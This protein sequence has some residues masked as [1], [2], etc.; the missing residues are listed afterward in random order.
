MIMQAQLETTMRQTGDAV[1]E[2]L[3]YWLGRS[4]VSIYAH[5]LLDLDVKWHAPLPGGAKILAANHPTTTDPFIILTL[6]PE[7]ISVLVTGGAFDVPL[8]GSYLRQAGHVP[9]L[10][11][12]GGRTVQQARELLEAG[13][14]VAIFPEGAL[15]PT[16]VG[17]GPTE[18]GQGP[19]EVGQGPTEV[20][21]GPT[22]VGQGP[23]GVRQGP[24]E[25]TM[26][27][28]QPHSGVARLA[29][30]TGAPVI[31]VGISLDQA[32]IRLVNVEM[33]GQAEEG[34]I[35]TGG[36]YA[37]TVGKPIWLKGNVA[38]W[39]FVHLVS[40]RIMD[41]IRRLSH[42]SSQRLSRE[43][44]RRLAQPPTPAG[45]PQTSIANL[46]RSSAGRLR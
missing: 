23:T 27:F 32:R 21:Q 24:I 34:R 8:F 6:L 13:R 4:A 28:H 35:Y 29:L 12:S 36:P 43:R 41:R 22:E 42:E 3:L 2:K 11:N 33:E 18:V 20:G 44:T 30:S 39:D 26:G 15:S 45:V 40:E 31:P 19:T 37:M 38:D 10:R 25:G 17:Q 16:E 5:T 1:R 7:P 14:T 46:A 9:V